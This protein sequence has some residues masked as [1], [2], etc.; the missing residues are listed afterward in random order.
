MTGPEPE[1]SGPPAAPAPRPGAP[2]WMRV[3]LVLSLAL[4]L[5]VAGTVL[6]GIAARRG[7]IEAGI[8]RDVASAIYLRA[9][10]EEHRARLAE[11]FRRTAPPLAQ[12]RATF[13]AELAATL[14][15]LRTEPFDAQ[16]FAARISH[17]RRLM[18]ERAQAGDALFVEILANATPAERRAYA[19]R[20]ETMLR[21]LRR[22]D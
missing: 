22:G 9:L 1:T 20:L 16:A 18:D 7:Q 12:R 21:R 15:L 4:N 10:P 11:H 17:Q 19:D 6:G 14:D 13:R 2:L 3:T 5:L 8:P